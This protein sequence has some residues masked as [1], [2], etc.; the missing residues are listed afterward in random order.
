MIDDRDLVGFMGSAKAIE[1]VQEWNSR[2]QCRRMG[3]Q[4]QVVRFLNS[5]RTEHAPTGHACGHHV[6]VITENR[7][8]VSGDT[9]CCDVKD[10]R[11]QLPSDFEHIGDH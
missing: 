11:R 5:C 10:G 8:S 4:G 7:K 1:E 2:L 6:T 3:N 9:S